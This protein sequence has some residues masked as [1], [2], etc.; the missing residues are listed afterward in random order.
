MQ[1]SKKLKWLILLSKLGSHQQCHVLKKSRGCLINDLHKIVKFA[2]KSNNLK[3][4][5]NQKKLFKKHKT[6]L[7]RFVCSK[8]VKR[9]RKILLQRT[10]GGGL[11]LGAVLPAIISLIG[12]AIPKLIG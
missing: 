6:F 4:V 1:S 11:I 10:S 12:S 3:L 2:Q 8:G 7:K 5:P 9:L